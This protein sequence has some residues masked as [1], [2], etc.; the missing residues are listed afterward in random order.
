[1]YMYMDKVFLGGNVH[2]RFSHQHILQTRRDKSRHYIFS[3]TD[4]PLTNAIYNGRNILNRG[5]SGREIKNNCAIV[6]H[7]VKKFL[8]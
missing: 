8:P 3:E 2:I 4:M 6:P 1:M 7:I 5:R